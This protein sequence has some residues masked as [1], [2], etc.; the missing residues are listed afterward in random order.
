MNQMLFVQPDEEQ[1]VTVG[2]TVE[3]E[4]DKTG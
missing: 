4:T 2:E 3:D 1:E